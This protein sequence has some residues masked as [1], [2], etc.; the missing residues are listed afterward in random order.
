MIDSE[1][2]ILK[3]DLNVLLRQI[4]KKNQENQEDEN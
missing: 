2:K 1:V 3:K 4:D